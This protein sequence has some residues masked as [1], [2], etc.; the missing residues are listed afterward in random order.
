MRPGSSIT[1]DTKFSVGSGTSPALGSDDGGNAFGSDGWFPGGGAFFS[2]SVSPELKLG[3]AMTGNFGAP[4]NYDD[5]W[6]GRYYVQEA[7]M[8]G[9]SLPAFHRLQ[10]RPT[11]SRS[12]RA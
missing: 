4:L 11:S 12:A 5:N 2:Y 6:V 3:F 1:A 8:L 9:M 7:T 10:G